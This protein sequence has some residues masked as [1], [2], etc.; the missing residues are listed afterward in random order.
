MAKESIVGA[1]KRA[2]NET[3]QLEA[4]LCKIFLEHF[5]GNTHPPPLKFLEH[6]IL[7]RVM[8]GGGVEIG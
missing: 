4:Q 6:V 5:Y 2:T 7:I 3:P 1:I 8:G